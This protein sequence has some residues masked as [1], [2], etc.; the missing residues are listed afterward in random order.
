MSGTPFCDNT[1]AHS[2]QVLPGGV[3]IKKTPNVIPQELGQNVTWTL[4]IENSGFGIIENVV[5]TDVLGAGLAYVSSS[6]AGVNAGQTTTWGTAE[7]GG[8]ASMNPG[9]KITIDITATV[10]A[11]EFLENYADVRWG[12]DMVTDCY[13]TA[14]TIPPS[15]ATASVQRIV[16][17]PLLQYTP[18]NISFKYCED[19]VDVNFTVTNI[20]DGRAHDVWLYADFGSLAVS[21]VSAGAV[22]NNIDKRFELAGPLAAAPGP[23]NTYDLS[24]RLNFNTWCGGSFPTGDLLWQTV[25]KDDCDNEF[26]PPV[27]LSTINAP[28]NTPSLS[29]GKSGGPSVVQIGDQ[30]IYI[31]TSSYSGPLNCGAGTTGDVTVTDTLPAGFTVLDAGGGTWV[32]GGGGTGGTITWTYTPPAT[33]NTSITVQVPDRAYCETYCFTTFTND[34]A[35]TVVDCCGCTLNATGSQTSAIECEELVGA[36]KIAAPV[37]GIRCTDIQYTNTYIFVDNAA[38]DTVDLSQLIFRED[39]DNEQEYVGGSLQVT[40]SGSGDITA[41]AQTGMTDTTPG[42]GGNLSINFSNC[43]TYGSVRNRTLTITYRLR[44]TE[45]TVSACGGAT[46]YS[47]SRLDMGMISGTEC[48][49]DGTIYETTPVSVDPPAMS[50]SITGLGQ[51]VHKCETRSITITLTQSSGT[52]NPKDVRLVLSGLNYYVVNPAATICGGDVAPTSCTPVQVGDDYVWY[53]ADGFNGGGQTAVLQM[54][55]QK[56]CTGSGDLAATAYYDDNCHDDANYD[57]SCS[58]TAT[59]TPGLLLNG[60][61]LIEKTPEVFYAATNTIL[62]KIYITNRGSGSAYNVWVDDVLGSGLDYVSAVVNNMTGVTVTADQDHNGGAING[63]TIAIAEM[64]AGQRREISF[65]ALLVN[66]NDLTNDVS[67]SWGCVGIDCQNVVTDSAAVEIPRPLLINT[68]VVTTP[69]NACSDPSGMI[70]LKNAGQTTCYNLQ[71]T[72]NLPAGLNYIPGST[73]WSLNGGPVNGPNAAYDPVVSG[74]PEQLYWSS[75]Q[76]AGLAVS[77]P[78]DTIVIEYDMQADC[79]FAGG[80]VTVA[81]SYQNPCGQ[82]FNTAVSVFTVAFREPDI[83]ITKTRAN[84]PITCG[85]LVEWTIEITN[86]NI[87]PLPIVYVKDTLGGGFTYDSHSWDPPF[88][89]IPMYN[90]APGFTWE[91]TNLNAS[92][93]ARLTFRAIANAVPP[94]L[95]SPDLDNTVEAWWGCGAPDGDPTTQPGTPGDNA[96]TCLTTTAITDV[97]TETREPTMGFLSIAL[98]P[99]TINACDDRSDLTVTIENTGPTDATQVD[100]VITLPDG[101]SYNS[102]V[103]PTVDCGSGA[104]NINPVVSGPTNNILTFR[105]I[106]DNA[107]GKADNLCDTVTAGSTVTLTFSVESNCYVSADLDFELYYYDCCDDTQYSTT[108]SE[109]LDAF[110][111]DIDITK[112]P[113]LTQVDCAANVTW[114]IEVTNNGTGNAEVV[115][116]EDTLGDWL[117]YVPGGFTSTV[118][119]A[120]NIFNIAGQTYGWEFN[121]LGPGDTETFTIQATLNPDGFPTQADCAVALRQNNVEVFWG[122]GTNADS[123]DND[124]TSTA[125]TCEYPTTATAGPVTLEMPNLVITGINPTITCNA[126][127]SFSGSITVTVRNQGDGDSTP[128]F[129]VSVDDG[130]GWSGTGTHNGTI[131]NGN[132]V[133]VTINT[134][135]WAPDCHVCA[136]PYS[137]TATV[138]TGNTVCECDES[139]NDFGPYSYTAPIPDLIVTDIDFSNVSCT[140]D[141]ISGTVDVIIRN[142]ACVAAT[143][144]EVSLTTDGCL[145]FSNET[146]ASL[147]AE[148]STTVS[149]TISGSWADCTVGNCQFTAVVDP[150]DAVCECDGTNNDRVETYST[151]LPDLIVTDI[152]FSNIT[153]FADNFSGFVSVMVQN[154]GFGSA[155]G[156]QVSLSTDGC[157]TFGNQT[158]LVPVGAGASTTVQFPITPPWVDCTDC[159]CQFTAAVDPTNV[160]CE[161]DG[162]N[163]QYT[164]SY[165]QNLPDLR[166]NSVTP[167][168]VCNSD[169]NLSGTVTVNVENIGCGDANNVVVRLLSTCGIVFADQTVNLTTSTNTDLTFNY[170]PDCSNCS[171]FFIAYIDLDDTI[172]ECTGANNIMGSLPFTIDVPDITVQTDTL[173]IACTGSEQV[174]VSGTVTLANPGCGLIFNGTVPMRFTLYDNTGCGGN[175]LDQWTQNFSPAIILPGGGTQAFAI[176]PRTINTNLCDNS[177]GCQVSIRVE[178][179]YTNA[180]CECDDTDNTYCADNKAVDIPDLGVSSDTLGIS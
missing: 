109:T 74:S 39:A 99:L 82:V 138:D 4:T 85:Q 71:I 143:N 174:T 8:F 135:T 32:P 28:A 47:W 38:L 105:D 61:L 9:D 175:V 59:E 103:Q 78:G 177:T 3:T 73:S 79:P 153:C 117:D 110:Y 141:N 66:C 163:N 142:N 95:C 56:R 166:V 30:I 41:C 36:D 128:T 130:K 49:Q 122:C 86:N 108:D 16:K 112:T 24:F 15:T 77:N 11:C 60:D 45:D 134:G 136:S 144:F 164:E 89:G 33:L 123:T 72:E 20:G 97:R 64:T 171:C 21:N 84:E 31:I 92:Q 161:C 126:D 131:N 2:I 62:W 52:A 10:I 139:D 57:D 14:D 173:A 148:T 157:F 65:T 104:V 13:N 127:G 40:L 160:I 55:V 88:N 50:L 113:T 58:V 180:I 5:V 93:T 68:N 94:P 125:Y 54:T 132:S 162:T 107:A 35:A 76:I 22:Y 25:Y 12:C 44:I 167:A 115:R 63:C 145:S 7:I 91:L 43:N 169:G 48:L 1:G 111:P 81:T 75:T 34:I 67:T 51:I 152:D 87:Y 37:T 17:T 137:F 133:D 178:A 118:V 19:D 42:A 119:P 102:T 149:F 53:F 100:L 147:A 170:T 114:T 90:T 179:D 29:V 124:P 83:T 155:V 151:T 98:N 156:F 116:I 27:E 168:A 96:G 146:V 69:A 150:T 140:N 158:V 6:P 120:I 70:T 80:N 106:T 176:T 26:Y 46:F 101:L 23:G 159:T 121:D 172:C 18:P 165:T 129:T 154:R